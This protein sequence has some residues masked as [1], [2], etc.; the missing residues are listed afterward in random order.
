VGQAANAPAGRHPPPFPPAPLN[1]PPWP[2][3]DWPFGGSPVIGGAT[4]NSSGGNLMKALQALRSA[5]FS[6]AIIS[7]SGAGSMVDSTS[8]HQAARTATCR[9]A[10]TIT[11]TRPNWTRR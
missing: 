1:S 9:P 2:W 11:R 3:P 10:M 4:P 6:K 5:L 7:R 8:A